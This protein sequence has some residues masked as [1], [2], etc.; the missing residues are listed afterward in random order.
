MLYYKQGRAA[1]RAEVE[2][3]LAGVV[4]AMASAW[5]RFGNDSMGGTAMSR[6]EKFAT[7][8]EEFGEVAK[9]VVTEGRNASE[10]EPMRHGLFDPAK[11]IAE[12]DQV[13]ACAVM[14]A[15]TERSA[16]LSERAE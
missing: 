2:G 6:P 3:A 16:L 11:L 7:L 8:G 4:G 14:W 5:E 13:A 15:E 10:H 12:L 1:G 9:E